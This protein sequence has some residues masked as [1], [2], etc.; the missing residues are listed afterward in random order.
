M[1]EASGI[2]WLAHREIPDLSDLDSKSILNLMVNLLVGNTP[3]MMKLDKGSAYFRNLVRLSDKCIIEYEAGRL[4]CLDFEAN[5]STQNKFS[6]LFRAVNHFENCITSLHRA[7]QHIDKL[8]ADYRNMGDIVQAA[9]AL[10]GA[11]ER[12]R[13]MRDAIEH[14]DKLIAGGRIGANE[15]MFMSV[16]PDG[17]H[18]EQEHIGFGELA[19]WVRSV[20]QVASLLMN[21]GLPT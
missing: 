20:N 13:R 19:G 15:S 9:R 17:L 5:V 4:A 14:T 2:D 12:L 6:P 11:K 10:K 7:V 21:W 8:G 18:L 3:A 1:T 16:Q